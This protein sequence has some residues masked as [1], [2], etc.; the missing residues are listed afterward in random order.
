M[1]DDAVAVAVTVA[2]KPVVVAVDLTWPIGLD[3]VFDVLDA[4]DGSGASRCD[5]VLSTTD[6]VAAAAVAYLPLLLHHPR[7][8]LSLWQHLAVVVVGGGG[9][10]VVPKYRSYSLHLRQRQR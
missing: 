1:A 4:I 10:V 7:L 2:V 3:D 6:A 5:T 8:H 9:V